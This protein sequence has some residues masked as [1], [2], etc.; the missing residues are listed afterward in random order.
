[1]PMHGLVGNNPAN[2]PD[3]KPIKSRSEFKPN[4]SL[5]MSSKFGQY[6]PFLG[7]EIVPDDR[8]SIRVASDV[9]TFTLKAPLMCPVKMN[10]DYFFVPYRAI[11]PKNSDLLVTNPKTGQDIVPENVN[12]VI[13][14]YQ[15]PYSLD[16]ILYDLNRAL[17]DVAND[18]QTYFMQLL[19]VA[20]GWYAKS[21]FLLSEASPA[22]NL[23][24]GFQGLFHG[25][26]RTASGYAG[27][28]RISWDEHMDLIWDLLIEHIENFEV[29]VITG[30]SVTSGNVTFDTDTYS[31]RMSLG[32]SDCE[33]G[34]TWMNL[35]R[36]L[37]LLQEGDYPVRLTSY[38][39]LRDASDT[40]VGPYAPDGFVSSI[41]ANAFVG[42][43]SKLNAGT[44]DTKVAK[45]QSKPINLDRLVGYQLAC[46]QFY[47]SDDVDYVYTSQLWHDNML[48]LA[49]AHFAN[50][51]TYPGLMYYTLNGVQ[52]E[53]DSVSG[54]ILD[55][56][57]TTYA[58]VYTGD[59]YQSGAIFDNAV[60]YVGAYF[61]M[62]NLFGFN[63]ALRFRD[64][65]VGSKTAPMAVGNVNVA[66]SGG[67]FSVVDVTKNIQRQRFLNQVNRV[68]RTLNEYV[69]GIFGTTPEF[70]PHTCIF[71]GTSTDV[72]GASETENT[73]SDQYSSA[74]GIT[75][76]LRNDSSRFAF[77]G[78]F[79]EFG[80]VVGIM[81]FDTSTPYTHTTDGE[82]FHVDR[83]DMFNPFMQTIGD[84]E[85]MGNE[86]SLNQQIPFAY[87]LRYSEY[88]QRYDRACGAFSA[89]Y[90]PG[91]AFIRPLD[92]LTT[93]GV[94]TAHLKPNFIRHLPSDFDQ[95]YL[96]LTKC[97][98]A[99]R[100][101]FIIRH[102]VSIDASRPML[103]APSIL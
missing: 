88:K 5:F 101:H 68:G 11:L 41:F 36:F 94:N 23:G 7:A 80:V 26:K 72:I 81:S 89:G 54:N 17:N 99:G 25:P 40:F 62:N 4:F 14:P 86:I 75:S 13:R 55:A 82:L 6:S 97:S 91:Y 76:K 10:K 90:L 2:D 79:K 98:P 28:N 71:L 58:S 84:Q 45:A 1:M 29:S 102:D 52:M 51:Q 53:Y 92:S 24:Y 96:S 35:T 93:P 78:S 69:R 27:T 3:K 38:P 73:G 42:Q 65:F 46:A 18:A 12:C 22:A 85:V 44:S 15:I 21:W 31:V 30:M 60:S 34:S 50:S 9:D 43:Y 67:S 49:R 48:S 87:Q 70:D 8:V 77:E 19:S 95:F 33:P 59:N 61:Y 39:T 100:F 56:I 57:S 63:R 47:T 32:T 37:E 103:A 64:Y 20:I 66:V 74:N 83:Y 16:T